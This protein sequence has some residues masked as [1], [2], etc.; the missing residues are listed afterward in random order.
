MKASVWTDQL[1]DWWRE[2]RWWVLGS[3]W[4]TVVLL[5]FLG[6]WSYHVSLGKKQKP[7]D[8]SRP[9]V[10][11]IAY[12]TLRLF[13]LDVSLDVDHEKGPALQ[14]ARF[15][16]PLL[17]LLTT[18]QAFITLFYGRWL[19]FRSQLFRN[20]VVIA[21]YGRKG[22]LL[23]DHFIRDHRRLVV[24][25]SEQANPFLKA[26][27]RL[28]VPVIV[29]DATDPRELQRARVHRASILVC[30]TGDD[31]TN[32]QVAFAAQ[33]LATGRSGRPLDCLVYVVDARL[34]TLLT[35][36]ELESADNDL[37][38]FHF[39]N[40]FDRGARIL[41][42]ES[43]PFAGA[44]EGGPRLLVVGLGPLSQSFVVQAVQAWSTA[45]HGD[46]V[47]SITV[48]DKEAKERVQ[49]L[50]AHY[51]AV[52]R[53]CLVEGL[54]MDPASARFE[55]ASF[56]F[57]EAG[58]LA[59]T[60]AYILLGDESAALDVTLT[61]LSRLGGRRLPLFLAM[62]QENRLL[63]ILRTREQGG[64]TPIELH[65]FGLLDRV[66]QPGLLLGTTTEILAQAI[67]D[68]YVRGQVQ[69]GETPKTNP[70][71]VAWD[72]LTEDLR[73][74]NRRQAE[75]I[76]SKL[77][78]AQCF[79]APRTD[80]DEPLFQFTRE[81]VESLARSEHQRFVDERVSQGWKPAAVKDVA[82]KLTPYL[83]PWEDLDEP[84]RELDRNAVRQ[85]PVLLA[86]VGFKI[87]RR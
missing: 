79:I 49:A 47:L 63:E 87:Q 21:G 1:E 70:S 53:H 3:L 44:V 4:V 80:W 35:E 24:L 2:H 83:I 86:K 8:L 26:L 7:P 56:L 60:K 18:L 69:L 41:L 31:R 48:V 59:F 12:E 82:K 25:E 62:E 50:A 34:C 37:F 43:S 20:H 68:S 64:G 27:P 36:Q 10:S 15:A 78:Q 6:L 9:E 38:R 77:R 11:D 73:E 22:R 55:E 65:A 85:L 23:A 67:H 45:G 14:I 76:G 58:N 74:S 13:S 39:F 51:P 29:G 42:D 33:T 40:P 30:L 16:A 75:N 28:G 5:G 17:L 61:I 71:I 84:A 72:R 46:E 32:A 54:S 66:L 19:L 52:D 81:E 57:D